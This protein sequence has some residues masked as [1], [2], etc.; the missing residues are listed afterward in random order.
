M[1]FP[2]NFV[3]TLAQLPDFDEVIDVRSPAEFAE[4]HIPGAINCPV[5]DDAERARVGTIYK[6]VSPFEARKTGGALVARNIA[7]HLEEQFQDR[8]KSWKPLIYC[9]RGGQRSGAMTLVLQQV[10]WAARQLEGGY[11]GYRREVLQRLETEPGRFRY[12]LLCGPTGSGKTALLHALAAQGGQVLDLEGLARHK[13]SVLGV[14]PGERQPSQK[15]FESALAVQLAAFDPLRPV[16]VE[17]ESKTVGGLRLPPALFA[18]MRA[19]EPVWLEAPFA[20]RVEFLLRDYDYFLKAPA[21][22]GQRL[23]RLVELHGKEQVAR[24]RAQVD[25]GAWEELV[26]SLLADHYDPAYRKAAQRDFARRGE[27]MTVALER[28]TGDALTEA[29]RGLLAV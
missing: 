10:G 18:A 25:A 6:Q 7:R 20:A 13:G 5:L 9:W 12:R 27:G 2:P 21:W 15:A 22:L 23:D 16:F 3:A 29:A 28:L 14:L 1:S 11:K 8:P 19:A 4:D 24:W 26:S 17:A